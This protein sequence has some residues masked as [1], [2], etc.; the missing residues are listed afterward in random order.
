MFIF[1]LF[2]IF[3]AGVFNQEFNQ[4]LYSSQAKALRLIMQCYEE[5]YY[6]S[7]TL[8]QPTFSSSCESYT[9]LDNCFAINTEMHLP[10]MSEFG[11]LT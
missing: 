9:Q 2:W 10:W 11:V 5:I 8:E 4:K 6:D 3:K 1:F 7:S